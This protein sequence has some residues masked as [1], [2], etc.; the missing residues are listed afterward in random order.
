M[1]DGALTG[2]EGPVTP[3][4]AATVVLVRDGPSGVEVFMLQRDPAVK[5][6][7]GNFVFP[8]G[9]VEDSDRDPSVQQYCADHDDAGASRRLGLERGG[10]AY[11]VAAVRECFE[12]SGVLLAH[13][14]RHRPLA[15]TG[16]SDL[17]ARVEAYQ[18][19]LID[20]ETTLAE[21]CEQLGLQLAT[22]RLHYLSHWITPAVIP[23]RFDTRFF[24]TAAP[25]GQR[26]RHCEQ[27]TIDHRWISPEDALT[28]HRRG[29]FEM[30]FPTVKTLEQLSGYA[31]AASLI[32]AVARRAEVPATQPRVIQGSGGTRIIMPGEPGYDA[33]SDN[34]AD[35]SPDQPE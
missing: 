17:A 22:R 12:E 34:D 27:E 15:M 13:D 9:V 14:S 10:L 5:F 23:K 19:A 29:Q 6:G 32:E 4:P 18:Q 20:G 8:G 31:S 7:G 3:R 24:V 28:A 26:A 30:M 25:P 35:D 1:S 33:A 2:S 16:E 11:W 21:V